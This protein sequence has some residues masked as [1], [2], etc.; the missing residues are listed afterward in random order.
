MKHNILLATIISLLVSTQCTTS[1]LATDK[2]PVVLG[3]ISEA[4]A[5][6]ELVRATDT[7]YDWYV[8]SGTG[9]IDWEDQ[10]LSA[11]VNVRIKRDSVIWVQISKL[12]IE[13]GR[14]LVTPDS[15]WFLNRLEGKYARYGT[16]DFFKKYNLPAEFDMFTKVF[17]GGAYVPPDITRMTIESDGGLFIESAS[18]VNARHWLDVSYQLIRSQVMDP[19]H[20]QWS[21]GYSS[22]QAV[23]SGQTFPFRRTNTLLID[24]KENLFD[25]EYS[26][27][28]VDVPHELPF[29]I[30]SHYEKM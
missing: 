25:L 17:T 8:A 6:L 22:Y 20:H 27:I 13:I 12:G 1:K 10:R 4:S 29:S 23:N 9:T 21:A 2:P 30:P 26:S 7:P 18:G 14:M 28:L 3:G 24:G 5:L 19:N 16:D 15:A 11:K